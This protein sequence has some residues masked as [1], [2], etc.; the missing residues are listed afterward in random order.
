[1]KKDRHANPTHEALL[2][3]LVWILGNLFVFLFLAF[4]ANV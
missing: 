2:I 1:M 4:V 3:L